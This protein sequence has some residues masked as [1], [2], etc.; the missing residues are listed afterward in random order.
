MQGFKRLSDG[1]ADLELD[2]PT[3]PEDFECL[4]ETAEMQGWLPDA[5]AAADLPSRQSGEAK[6][7]SLGS[8]KA[9]L[10]TALKEYQVSGDAAEV[11]LCLSDLCQP[12]LHSLVV[13]KVGSPLGPAVGT[14]GGKR[15]QVHLMP[16]IQGNA[17]G[18]VLPYLSCCECLA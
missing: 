16:L 4:K 13:K 7:T 11:A 2:L 10:A 5:G 8:F 6:Q 18:K 3:A 9:A 12:G 1:L 17:L 14:T 15:D